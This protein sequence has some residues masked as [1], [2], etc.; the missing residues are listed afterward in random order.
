MSGTQE[1]GFIDRKLALAMLATTSAR[2]FLYNRAGEVL[3]ANPA[4]LEALG[5]AADDVIGET[6]AA[7]GLP[8]R[9]VRALEAGLDAVFERDETVTVCGAFEVEGEPRQVE[10]VISPIRDAAG[11]VVAALATTVDVSNHVRTEEAL[12]HAAGL[13]QGEDELSAFTHTVA[14]GLQNPL[15]VIA[16]YALLLMEVG[17]DLP[18]EQY[19]R[20]VTIIARSAKKMSRLLSDLLLLSRL[21][22]EEVETKPLE[23]GGIVEAALDQM[24]PLITQHNAEVSVP[25]S[26]P[27]V[28]GYA[29][30]IE[31]VWMNYI[32]NAIKYGGR[33]PRVELGAIEQGNGLVRCWVRDNGQGLTPEEQARVFAPPIRLGVANIPAHGLGLSIVKQVVHKLG[34]EVGVESQAGEGCVFTFTLPGVPSRI[35][36]RASLA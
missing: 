25:D 12:R 16:G 19:Q 31:E 4:A 20:A 28:M 29:P 14:H 2:L 3:Y 15:G 8:D 10:Q 24:L 22:R 9:Y 26:W 6:W 35:S 5:K 23:M 27:L 18:R 1:P 17:G 33:P 30:W 34:G 21:G 7:I 36:G 32:S 13:E 11:Q